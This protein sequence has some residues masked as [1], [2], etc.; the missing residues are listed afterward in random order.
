MGDGE[1]TEGGRGGAESNQVFLLAG[2]VIPER[3]KG[4]TIGTRG[5]LGLGSPSVCREGE[6]ALA[7]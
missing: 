6:S 5:N 1:G 2:L 4:R 3:D 7:A